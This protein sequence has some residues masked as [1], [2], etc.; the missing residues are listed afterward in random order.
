MLFYLITY[1]IRCHKRRKKVSD[2]LEG[3]GQRVQLSVF[4]CVLPPVKYKELKRRLTPHINCQEDSLRFYPLSAHTL[5]TVDV[6]GGNPLTQK[7][8]SAVA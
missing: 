7:S 1:D 5:S 4:E 8:C 6:W 3:Y 2:L